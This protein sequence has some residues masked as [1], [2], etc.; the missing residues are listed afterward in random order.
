[1]KYIPLNA[2]NVITTIYFARD[3]FIKRNLK[4]SS[5]IALGKDYF[6]LGRH[7]SL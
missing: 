7:L 5:G 6:T 2:E 3:D 4:P 1:M